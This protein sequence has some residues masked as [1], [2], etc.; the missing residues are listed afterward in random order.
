MSKYFLS[1]LIVFVLATSPAFAASKRAVS[2]RFVERFLSKISHKEQVVKPEENL[3][4][5]P[6]PVDNHELNASVLSLVSSNPPSGTIYAGQPFNPDGTD[7]WSQKGA[8][9]MIQV[10]MSGNVAAL[11]PEMFEVTGS[12]PDAP[13]VVGIMPTEK[14][15]V[16]SLVL[17]HPIQ[18]GWTTITL[19][20]TGENVRLGYLPGDVT[21][22]GVFNPHDWLKLIDALNGA[23]DLP[24]YSTD[25]DNS[26]KFTSADLLR[27]ID[28]INGADRYASLNLFGSS[29]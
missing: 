14:E 6:Q 11:A 24:L 22:D 4:L 7:F 20:S 1:A 28:L 12:S 19:K 25:I 5:K 27:L 17:S 26:G 29:I 8:P 9:M 23:A 2:L 15:G 18:I 16:V 3:A 13:R 21:G 10:A